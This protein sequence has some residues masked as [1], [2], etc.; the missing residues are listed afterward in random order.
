M[1]LSNQESEILGNM[2]SV[3]ALLAEG[4][5]IKAIAS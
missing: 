1:S 4:Q 2:N 5:F 3:L